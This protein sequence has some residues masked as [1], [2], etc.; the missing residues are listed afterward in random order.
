[1][2]RRLI[3]GRL[4]ISII[5]NVYKSIGINVVLNNLSFRQLFEYGIFI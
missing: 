3:K 5:N 4:I 1:M 2:H